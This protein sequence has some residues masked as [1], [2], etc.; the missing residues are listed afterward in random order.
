MMTRVRL[1]IGT[2]VEP[3]GGFNADRRAAVRALRDAVSQFDVGA[4]VSLTVEHRSGDAAHV[5][6]GGEE[7]PYAVSIAH[8]D[9]HAAAVVA[10]AG[11]RVGID[12]ERVGSVNP[13]EVRM[14]AAQVERVGEIDATTLWVLKEAAWKA[15]KCARDTPFHSVQ[16]EFSGHVLTAVRL[17][18]E[19]WEARA[20]VWTPWAR[21]VGAIVYM[22]R[23]Q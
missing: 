7:L 12:I 22:S 6:R 8:G 20:H 13:A 15:L 5:R 19:R 11:A 3:A 21:W 16:L 17:A 1:A 23:I 10:D 14:F 9:G 2:A 4:A 18:D